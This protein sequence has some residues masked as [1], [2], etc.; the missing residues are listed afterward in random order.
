M[1]KY[2]ILFI[3]L[4]LSVAGA[5]QTLTVRQQMDW[6]HEER[7]VNFVY[8]SAINVGQAYTGPE[9]KDLSLPKALKTLFEGTGIDYRQ[10]GKYIMLFERKAGKVKARNYTLSGYVRDSIGETLINATVYDLTTRQGTMTNEHGYYSL[11]LPEGR[12][13]LRIA[14]VGFAE[15]TASITLNKNRTADY[16]LHGSTL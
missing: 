10:N 13:L 7:G 4:M 9:L 3:T 15:Q 16:T 6:L 12:H 2:I 5:A 11:T 14:Y 1:K 8:D